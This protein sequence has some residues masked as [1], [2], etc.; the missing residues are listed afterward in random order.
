M[1]NNCTNCL[2]STSASCNTT[3]FNCAI[4]NHTQPIDTNVQLLIGSVNLN[5]AYSELNTQIVASSI[6]VLCGISVILISLSLF[7]FLA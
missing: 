3:F 2:N 4:G 1:N 5:Q 7:G 6:G